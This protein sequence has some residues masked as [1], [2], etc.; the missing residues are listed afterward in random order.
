MPFITSSNITDNDDN[1]ESSN[2][3][4]EDDNIPCIFDNKQDDT[5]VPAPHVIDDTDLD[6]PGMAGLWRDISKSW[7]LLL[8]L[9]IICMYFSLTS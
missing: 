8:P 4:G 2:P 3:D 6:S 9:F 1:K 5:G 7:D